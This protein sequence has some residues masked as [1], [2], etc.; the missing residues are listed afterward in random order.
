[1]IPNTDQLGSLLRTALKIVGSLL[2]SHGVMKDNPALWEAISGAVIALAPVIYDMLD[3]TQQ[4]TVSK[5]AALI[6]DPNSPVQGLVLAAT[7]EGVALAASTTS[8]T[9]G[10]VV[11]GTTDAVAIAK[12]G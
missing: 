2:A 5:V 10:V 11:A 4:A 7:K 12:A 8:Q 6:D 1:M 9:G 3:K